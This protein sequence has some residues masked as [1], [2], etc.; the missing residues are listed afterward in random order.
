M[1]FFY[2]MIAFGAAMALALIYAA[3]S[4]N[5]AERSVEVATLRAEGV[6]QRIL[7]RLITAENL[8]VTLLGIPPGIGLGFLLAKPLL[9]TYTND[10]WRFD[11]VVAPATPILTG[12][13]I[14]AAALVSQWPG[15]RAVNRLDVA[16]V[17]RLR[18]A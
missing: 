1:A 16:S 15:L 4:V 3:I 2:A 14:C 13:A 5:I 8:I 7:S 9:A 18:S 11:L 10:L 6:R 12:V 17:V